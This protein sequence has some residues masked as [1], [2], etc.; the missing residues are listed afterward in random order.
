MSSDARRLNPRAGAELKLRV[1]SGTGSYDV[2]RKKGH[3]T[4][5]ITQR[6]ENGSVT[7]GPRV[8]HEPVDLPEVGYAQDHID[9]HSSYLY[10]GIDDRSLQQ[11]V[12]TDREITALQMAGLR[13][14]STQKRRISNHIDGNISKG[15]GQ[16]GCNG[17]SQAGLAELA[18][19]LTKART[20]QGEIAARKAREEAEEAKAL[21]I[22]AV[23][24]EAAAKETRDKRAKRVL[25]REE[26]AKAREEV[27]KA[28]EE[29]AKARKEAEKAAAKEKRDKRAQLRKAAA[30]EEAEKKEAAAETAA[31]K[32]LNDLDDGLEAA[33]LG[34]DDAVAVIDRNSF[35]DHKMHGGPNTSLCGQRAVSA[36]EIGSPHQETRRHSSQLPMRQADSSLTSLLKGNGAVPHTIKD[37]IGGASGRNKPELEMIGSSHDESLVPSAG[38][39]VERSG[40]SICFDE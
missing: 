36:S 4:H 2:L 24:K 38:A 3:V 6:T 10:K 13:N 35:E 5:I 17:L 39:S 18:F 7:S 28:R 19:T 8:V 37:T 29:V 25:L 15:A 30:K 27:A 14:Q 20:P 40:S 11:V 9:Q 16:Y 32:A 33:D 26:V 31:L 23:A 34:F 1:E 21:L 12:A 22:E